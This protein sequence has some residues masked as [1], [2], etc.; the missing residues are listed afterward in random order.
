[1]DP[2]GSVI[3]WSPGSGALD[4]L[5]GVK[6]YSRLPVLYGTAMKYILLVGYSVPWC[7]LLFFLQYYLIIIR[8]IIR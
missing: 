1:M 4:S 2:A 6:F 5:L 3:N 8:R 7:S